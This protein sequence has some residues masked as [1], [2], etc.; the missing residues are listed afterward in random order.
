[1]RTNCL[2]HMNIQYHQLIFDSLNNK[3]DSVFINEI[4]STRKIN[5][6]LETSSKKHW[7]ELKKEADK[8]RKLLWDSE[9]YRFEAC[10]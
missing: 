8:A 1:M 5:E 4:P 10:E 9:T 7:N 6:N 3:H 2:I